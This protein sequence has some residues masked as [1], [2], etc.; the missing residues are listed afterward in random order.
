MTSCHR[1]P[2]PRNGLH[3]P[4]VTRLLE[5]E[6]ATGRHGSAWAGA[7]AQTSA[8]TT[9][10]A[11]IAARH[12]CPIN[13]CKPTPPDCPAARTVTAPV[14]AVNPDCTVFDSECHANV[15]NLC[16]LCDI[17]GEHPRPMAPY[18]HPPERSPDGPRPRS[19]HRRLNP[20]R[21]L[22]ELRRHRRRGRRQR[23][24]RPDPQPALHPRGT[25]G[26]PPRPE[27]RRHD[28]RDR[29]RRPRPRPSPA[30]SR[31]PRV[32]GRPRRPQPPSAPAGRPARPAGGPHRI[33]AGCR[34][35]LGLPGRR[36]GVPDGSA[37]RPRRAAGLRRT[38]VRRRVAVGRRGATPRRCRR[39]AAAS[40]VLAAS[41]AAATPPRDLAE[42]ST[43][44]P[45][46]KTSRWRRGGKAAKGASSS[47]AA[48]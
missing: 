44:S 18:G 19:P 1:F 11:A 48:A 34:V 27:V 7:L 13:P 8:S 45:P 21:R 9:R 17:A 6:I 41:V 25:P 28:R 10:V 24:S 31:G 39:P 12:P 26:R 22:D 20:A 14:Q 23:R 3:S 29:P 4:L 5:H 30:R 40:D 32:R 2:P 35:A 33:V 38:A 36:V 47:S 15:P 42:A 46:A 43:D 16:Q 37:G